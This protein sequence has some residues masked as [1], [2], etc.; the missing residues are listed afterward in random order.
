MQ[1]VGNCWPTPADQ[2]LLEAGLKDKPQAQRAW[3]Q[4]CRLVDLKSVHF[5]SHT[6]FP[7]VFKKLSPLRLSG[8][9]V[10]KSMY[11]YMWS[12]NHAL[13][14]LLRQVLEKLHEAEIQTCL[15][16]GAALIDS[17]YPDAA[18]RRL[19]DIDL[20]V[21]REKIPQTLQ[22]LEQFGFHP[23]RP[24]DLRLSHAIPLK[25]ANHDSIDLHWD[26]LTESWLDSRMRSFSFRTQPSS[27]FPT[28]LIFGPEDLLLHTLFHGVRHSE[29]PLIRW[30]PD[31]VHILRKSPQMDWDYFLLQTSRLDIQPLVHSALTYLLEREFVSFPIQILERLH[32][33][34]KSQKYFQFLTQDPKKPFAGLKMYWHLHVRNSSS[35]NPLILL[36]GFLPFIKRARPQESWLQLTCFLI[37]KLFIHCRQIFVKSR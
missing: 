11:Q 26:V 34:P 25:N 12:A 14:F 2:L 19:G 24:L 32:W 17:Y 21:A 31:A 1:Y 4:Y 28:A 23:D 18:S 7:L 27:L 8:L 15:L 9:D 6:F 35:E 29:V 5:V 30:I 13:F 20:L 3:E 22:L 37:K 36:K 16:K 33:T 10:C